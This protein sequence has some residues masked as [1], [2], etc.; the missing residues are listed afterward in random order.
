MVEQIIMEGRAVPYIFFFIEFV[1]SDREKNI[2]LG[3]T[4]KVEI[5]DGDV[6]V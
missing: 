3:R 2:S 1:S 5:Y 4:W 6:N